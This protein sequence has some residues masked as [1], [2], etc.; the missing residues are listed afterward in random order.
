MKGF[1]SRSTLTSS[2]R[3]F[4]L[5][6]KYYF[7]KGES[8]CAA[9][10]GASPPTPLH[11]LCEC[12]TLAVVRCRWDVPTDPHFLRVFLLG[13]SSRAAA[14]LAG[15]VTSCLNAAAGSW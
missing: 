2:V 11:A 14:G 13:L 3:L 4:A 1:I 9:C 7:T 6:H 12:P 10:G 5:Q 8:G 15:D